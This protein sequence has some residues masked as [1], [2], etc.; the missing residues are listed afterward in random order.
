MYM[1]KLSDLPESDVE[2]T[3]QENEILERYFPEKESKGGFLQALKLS[4]GATLLFI[5]LSNSIVDSLLTHV[6]FCGDSS[7]TI[8]GIKVA[9]FFFIMLIFYKFVS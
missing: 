7:L 9:M 8:M 4:G 2:L 3:P 5:L 6:P 1:D